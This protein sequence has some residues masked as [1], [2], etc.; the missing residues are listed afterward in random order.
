MLISETDT[1]QELMTRAH[2]PTLTDE[3]LSFKTSKTSSSKGKKAKLAV[4]S[5]SA[6][7]KAARDPNLPKRPT[8][9]YLMFCEKEKERIKADHEQRQSGRPVTE[10][11][12][13]LTDAWKTLDEDERKPYI[14]LYEEDR[15]RYRREMLT[16]NRNKQSERDL[17]TQYGMFLTQADK[18]TSNGENG[19]E[20]ERIGDEKVVA[21]EDEA[22]EEASIVFSGRQPE[23]ERAEKF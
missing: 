14:K 20:A 22:A 17:A 8:N 2:Y 6:T 15:E 9:A 1:P 10:I 23:N 13:L 18:K 12:R 16:Y 7:K 21:D 11:A 4:G 19:D 5:S 3:C